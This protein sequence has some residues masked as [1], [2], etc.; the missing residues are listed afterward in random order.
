MSTWGWVIEYGLVALVFLV[1]VGV[2]V[3]LWGQ[4]RWLR[5]LDHRDAKREARAKQS[6]VSPER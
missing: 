3:Y 6:G 5:W 2:F 1:C 4:D